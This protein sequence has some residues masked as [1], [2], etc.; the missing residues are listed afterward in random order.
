[1][2]WT[3]TKWQRTWSSISRRTICFASISSKWSSIWHSCAMRE[4]S[5]LMT[6]RAARS[7]SQEARRKR[8]AKSIYSRQSTSCSRTTLNQQ[9]SKSPTRCRLER[10]ICTRS[11]WTSTWS[12][13]NLSWKGFTQSTFT[14][15]S[16]AWVQTMPSSSSWGQ[17]ACTSSRREQSCASMASQSSQL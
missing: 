10:S 13:T 12:E 15:E 7:Q 1:M 5:R 4:T 14:L 3:E 17:V 16:T 6:R 11:M 2:P 9:V 8:V